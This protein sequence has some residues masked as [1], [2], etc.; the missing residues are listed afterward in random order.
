V[1]DTAYFNL[2]GR[3][4]ITCMQAGDACY[5]PTD[6]HYKI[7][8][9]EKGNQNIVAN[10]DRLYFSNSEPI[11]LYI[12]VSSG[13]QPTIESSNPQV[14][15]FVNGFLNVYGIGTATLTISQAGNNNYLPANPLSID[16]EVTKALQHVNFEVSSKLVY[17]NG[18]VH[19]SLNNESGL[20]SELTSLSDNILEATHDSLIVK[21]AGT[22][23]INITNEG[24]ENWL[25]L[26]TLIVLQIEKGFQ[27][28]NAPDSLVVKFSNNL[29]DI[30]LELNSG[31]KIEYEYKGDVLS[32]LN[33]SFSTL[34]TGFERVRIF[35]NGNE[36]WH[37][38]EHFVDVFVEKGEQFIEFEILDEFSLD[39]LGVKLY[40]TAGSGLP[41]IYSLSDT[42]I[43]QLVGA[44]S[45]I[46]LSAGVVDISATQP[47][48]DNWYEALQVTRQLF[49]DKAEQSITTALGD[50]LLVGQTFSWS[51]F[52]ASSGLSISNIISSNNEV[53]SVSAGSLNVLSIGN[54]VLTITQQ[55]D[56]YY[57]PATVDFNFICTNKTA[58]NQSRITGYALYP[59]PASD[60]VI[61]EFNGKLSGNEYVEIYGTAG[62]LLQ[63]K[64]VLS[65]Y[66]H[67][68][69]TG[70]LPG[71]YTLKISGATYFY[72]EKLTVK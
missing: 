14:A 35:N 53:V 54:V 58:I 34:K 69:L 63:K 36:N 52:Q 48:N 13:L 28:Q 22:A 38:F 12:S 70:F 20:L 7:L 71:I 67:I 15:D 66:N 3:A 21:G 68:D 30:P 1:A 37:D 62:Q 40:A 42:T 64:Q 47:G 6:V 4:V 50:T 24:N 43:A 11:A 31:L 2:V 23:F 44:D 17:G 45:I 51:D 8:T 18:N 57:H 41:V 72:Y 10:I 55:G 16:I 29:F 65:Y 32:L 59:N 60:F 25:P 39:E 9:I 46:F 56:Y 19:F 49:I 61:F 33:G 26:D 27:L 5:F